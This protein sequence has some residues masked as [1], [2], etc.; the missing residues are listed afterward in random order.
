[1]QN[2]CLLYTLLLIL[3]FF[4]SASLDAENIPPEILKATIY[5]AP[6]DITQYWVS[7]KYD[8]IRGY[9]TGKVLLTKQGNLIN[10]P[11]WF[12]NYWPSTPLDGELWIARDH[13][14]QTMSV[15]M[16]SVPNDSDWQQIR[17]MVFDLPKHKGTFTERITE[18]K[19]LINGVNSDYLAVIEQNKLGNLH[20]LQQTLDQVVKNKGE[21]LMLHHQH[22]YYHAGRSNQ[23]MK[24]KQYQDA[25]AIVL[26]HISGKGKYQQ[27]LG[28]L[29]VKTT[30]GIT[31][32]I[33]SGF[34]DQQRQEPPPIGTIITYKYIGKTQRGVPRFASF[35]RIRQLVPNELDAQH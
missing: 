26:K 14:Q 13:F 35:L 21:G 7:E 18:M 31:F 2:S 33:G 28:S 25:E 30:E 32:K 16:R 23:L 29:L 1:M 11:D 12:T 19:K 20:E 34:S 17:F 5:K 22:A 24:L 3:T 6:S 27:Q 10:H 9:W 8:G 15:V 4:H